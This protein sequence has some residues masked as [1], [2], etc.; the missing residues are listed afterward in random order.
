[1]VE[2]NYVNQQVAMEI[3]GRAGIAAQT[4]DNG[5]AAIKMLHEKAF[6]AVLMDVQ[7]PVMDGFKA[8][9]MI[10]QDLRL[11]NLPIIAMTAHAMQGDREM[12]LNA[13]MNDYVAKPIDRRQLLAALDRWLQR[14]ASSPGAESGS[15]F[16]ALDRKQAGVDS[17]G[18]SGDAPVIMDIEDALARLGIEKS[19]FV[20]LASRFIESNRNIVSEI[21]QALES[22]NRDEARR[23]AHT[24]KGAAGSLSA[25]AVYETARELESAIRG[26]TDSGVREH[27]LSK[28]DNEMKAT[29]VCVQELMC[30]HELCPAEATTA[31]SSDRAIVGGLRSGAEAATTGQGIVGKR[32]V[33][34][35]LDS[36]AKRE[37]VMRLVNELTGSIGAH[38]PVGSE[39]TLAFLKSLLE[40]DDEDLYLELIAASL[41]DYDFPG[42]MRAVEAL[43]QKIHILPASGQT[44]PVSRV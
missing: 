36:T 12:C 4:A 28:L 29:E 37:E 5:L 9:K 33:N 18:K 40:G 8:T 32:T 14:S 13:G 34:D 41:D 44:L 15:A 23:C 2:D 21:R 3:L 35:A 1:V 26:G 39:I 17:S 10:R 16:S 38:D 27:L 25:K 6:D 24:L 7:M 42:A 22:G 19:F 43:I 31:D 30:S 11:R 20:E